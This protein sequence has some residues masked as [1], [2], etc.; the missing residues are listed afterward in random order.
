[1]TADESLRYVRRLA[2]RF[3]E[4]PGVE[5]VGIVN[6]LPLDMSFSGAE[7]NVDGHTPPEG[8]ETF[9]ADRADVDG[10]FFDA[11][12]I[13]ILR[14]RAFN[15]ADDSESPSVAIISEAMARRY[16]PAGDA[17]GRLLRRP[18]SPAHRIVG[19]AGDI[20]VRTL[21]EAPR[22]MIYLPYTQSGVALINFVVRTSGDP[23]ELALSVM[24]AGREV[25]PELRVVDTKT[26]TQHLLFMKLPAQLEAFIV[27]A[28]AV[29][30][31]ILA[32]IGVFG[33]VRYTV[34][35][36]MREVGIRLALGADSGRVARGLAR[37]GVRLVVVGGVIGWVVSLGV[38]RL[39]ESLVFGVDAFDTVTFAAATLLLG[40][41]GCLAAYLPSRRA[42]RVD[43]IAVLRSD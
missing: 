37:S 8:R 2:D 33:A 26:M 15:D 19:V 41:A 13:P 29:L 39:L 10:A 31:L 34:A 27:S 40:A 14:G 11:A 12:G 9:R 42:S 17:V 6:D 20:K 1:M 35:T 16:W 36:R 25:D 38:S 4:L 23:A 22:D 32:T 3:R 18:N 5:A 21:G 28:F 7:F 24:T 30:A 43:P